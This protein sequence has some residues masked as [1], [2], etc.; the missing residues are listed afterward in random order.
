ML[1]IQIESDTIEIYEFRG[2]DEL[3][4]QTFESYCRTL[5]IFLQDRRQFN[6]IRCSTSGFLIAKLGI[7]EISEML[8]TSM[9]ALGMG[10][11]GRDSINVD[12]DEIRDAVELILLHMVD[13]L[14]ISSRPSPAIVM[15]NGQF[16]LA[17]VSPHKQLAI[18]LNQFLF[19][20]RYIRTEFKSSV[21]HIER[22]K[23]AFEVA[24]WI[25]FNYDESFDELRK[26]LIYLD[27]TY[28]INKLKLT[29]HET[30]RFNLVTKRQSRDVAKILAFVREVSA[31]RDQ[32][33]EAEWLP[34]RWTQEVV[35]NEALQPQAP[36]RT[37][38]S[39]IY[40]APVT[41]RV[42]TKGGNKPKAEAKPLTD[43]ARIKAERKANMSNILKSMFATAPKV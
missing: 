2:Q 30:T 16:A 9:Y 24:D 28:M 21:D 17:H 27:S 32:H 8:V 10:E 29:K 39:N 41:G 34:L 6:S 26:A 31:Y 3:L 33:A 23:S 11:L 40:E 12:P 25:D 19:D 14:V 37:Q 18:L 38:F 4:T 35:R 13:R 22:L 15:D 7:V 36:I 42:A 1:T 43:E 20:P 5:A